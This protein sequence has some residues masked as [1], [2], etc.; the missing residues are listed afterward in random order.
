[1]KLKHLLYF[2]GYRMIVLRWQANAFIG[3]AEFEPDEKGF[4]AFKSLLENEIE[5]PVRLLVDILEEDFRVET[6][7]HVYGRDRAALHAR[8]LNKYFRQYPHKLLRIQGR[9]EKGRRDD[10]VLLSALTNPA[11]FKPWVDI[12]HQLKIPLEGIYSLPL[13]GEQL[14]RELGEPPRNVLVISQQVP[15][16]I[17]QSF[18]IEGKLKLSRLAPSSDEPHSYYTA[19]REETQRTVRYLENQNLI[20]GSEPLEVFI[21][22]PLH[23]HAYLDEIF[24]DDT[25]K[26]FHM[27]NRDSLAAALEI[28][29]QLPGQY[30]N[31]LYA[32]ILLKDGRLRHHYATRAERK[33]FLYHQT[34]VGLYALSAAVLSIAVLWGGFL[35]AQ[36]YSFSNRQLDIQLETQRYERLYREVV[37]D[38]SDLD[39]SVE[40][41]RDAVDVAQQLMP[42]YEHRPYSLMRTVSQSLERNEKVSLKSIKWLVTDDPKH[43]F[44]EK[45]RPQDAP[46]KRGLPPPRYEK[47]LIEAVVSDYEANPRIAVEIVDTFIR[48]MRKTDPAYTVDIIK[49]PFDVDSASRMIGQGLER[50]VRDTE[51]GF[52]FVVV[53]EEKPL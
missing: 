31:W 17:R 14:I 10:V 19:L 16:N 39:L 52:S 18:Y 4:A 8:L 7:P 40:D 12:L 13:V 27:L 42:A 50:S 1:M 44:G 6:C 51:A 15:G 24:S 36:A 23:E 2:A 46:A 34:R 48:D 53:K 29:E 38:I 20:T 5:A 3:S 26:R 32:H 41:I 43:S 28:R 22:A 21:V 49:M 37:A 11:L 35:A 45:H 30:C 25:R 9:Q 33:Y 47:A